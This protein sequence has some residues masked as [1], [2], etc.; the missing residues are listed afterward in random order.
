MGWFRND[1][2]RRSTGLSDT[3]N[4]LLIVCVSQTSGSGQA[5][6]GAPK[7]PAS[8]FVQLADMARRRWKTDIRATWSA[9][10]AAAQL[11]RRDRNCISWRACCRRLA[12]AGCRAAKSG[13]REAGRRR[14]R[15]T[16][17]LSYER[18]GFA[19]RVIAASRASMSS[20]SR[21]GCSGSMACPAFCRKATST[22]SGYADRSTSALAGAASKSCRA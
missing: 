21:S 6:G 11:M 2:V 20:A 19:R 14:S 5:A 15:R 18:P 22:R 7:R 12:R 10:S 17:T 1:V 3:N 4:Q 16:Q 9:T 13:K 8:G